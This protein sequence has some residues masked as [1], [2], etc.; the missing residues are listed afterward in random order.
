MMINVQE[1]NERAKCELN[2]KCQTTRKYVHALL[3]IK[4]Y[5]N[6]VLDYGFYS[7]EICLVNK[8]L[9]GMYVLQIEERVS[10]FRT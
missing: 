6:Y 4:F 2:A 1:F 5:E 7:S 9:T 3:E 10:I 8:I